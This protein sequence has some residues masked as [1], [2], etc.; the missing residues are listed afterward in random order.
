MVASI[1][2]SRSLFWFHDTKKLV[3]QCF[4]PQSPGYVFDENNLQF[5]RVEMVLTILCLQV[6]IIPLLHLRDSFASAFGKQWWGLDFKTNSR[7]HT[8]HTE[9]SLLRIYLLEN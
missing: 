5:G 6:Q 2:V 1:R 7:E 8:T 4:P 9:N 3:G